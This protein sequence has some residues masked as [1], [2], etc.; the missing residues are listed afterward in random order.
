MK[1]PTTTPILHPT[2]TAILAIL[3]ISAISTICL[4][5]FNTAPPPPNTVEL[6]L[7]SAQLAEAEHRHHSRL[8][9][10]DGR[11]ARVHAA[12]DVLVAAMGVGTTDLKLK[13]G[14]AALDGENDDAVVVGEEGDGELVE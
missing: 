3:S 1:K 4:L 2:S 7:L 14:E 8:S 12:L 13:S 6:R 11:L 10:I 5:Y 9:I